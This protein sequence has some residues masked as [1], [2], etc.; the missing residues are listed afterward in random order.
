[1]RAFFKIAESSTWLNSILQTIKN[2]KKNRNKSKESKMSKKRNLALYR[3]RQRDGLT[4]V[5]ALKQNSW[6][7]TGFQLGKE[8]ERRKPPN[9]YR[10]LGMWKSHECKKLETQKSTQNE[11]VRKNNIGPV[12]SSKQ[13]D[14]RISG[15]W[16]DFKG[17]HPIHAG[18]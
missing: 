5:N 14:A 15:C 10:F 3:Y 7:N 6:Q 16:L 9:G 18:N 2:L 11:S 4:K 12:S 17:H 8:R 1:M 13:R